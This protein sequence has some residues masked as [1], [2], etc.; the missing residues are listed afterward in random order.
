MTSQP[1]LHLHPDDDVAVATRRLNPGERLAIPAIGEV[2]VIDPIEAGHK[3]AVRSR[4]VGEVLHKYGQMIGLAAEPIAIGQWV[5]VHNCR[6]RSGADRGADPVRDFCTAVPDWHPS[7]ADRTFLGYRRPD[8]RVATRNYIGVVTTVNCSATTARFVASEFDRAL[9]ADY[10]QVDGVI[11]LTHKAGCA[12]EY[13]GPDHRQLN[14]TLAGFAR[15]PNIAA[16]LVLGLGCETAQASFLVQHGGLVQLEAGASSAT[17]APLVLNIQEQGG[18]RKT[19]AR[20]VAAIKELLPEVNRVARQPVPISELVL[21]LNCGGSDGNSGI[22]A[23][24]ALGVASDLLVRQGGTSVLAETP[25]IVGG[26]HLLTRRAVTPQV[27]Q[28]L[29]DRINWWHQYMA[30]FDATID[31]N[32]SVGNKAGGLTTI[33]EKSLGAI[34]KGGTAPL[35]AVYEYAEPILERGFVY[36]DTPGYD[37]ASVTGLI[38]GGCN[39]VCFTTGRG[40]C[41]GCKPV[42][43]VKIATNTS[44]YRRMEDDMDLNA[45]VILEG[46]SVEEVGQQILDKIISVA[47]GEKSKGEAQG[48]GDEEFCPWQPGPVT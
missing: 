32:P 1:A 33:Y 26:E 9:L 19:V 30:R 12:I 29:V 43:T 27:A 41:F 22:T 17:P 2:V 45:G 38:A 47:S 21:G 8:G 6:V 24:P 20:A 28:R 3:L 40:S 37:P 44:M 10:P 31:N 23:N 18:I 42:P 11:A 13:G 46:R 5:H 39:I 14:R 15:H 25:E 16:Y 7:P 36:M 35:Q 4:N 34:A 48:V